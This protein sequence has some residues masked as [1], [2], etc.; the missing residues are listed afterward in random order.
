MPTGFAP[1]HPILREFDS[2]SSK[3]IDSPLKYNYCAYNFFKKFSE[4]PFQSIN[5]DCRDTRARVREVKTLA[6]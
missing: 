2:P 3:Y 6:N 1:P 5:H 4:T